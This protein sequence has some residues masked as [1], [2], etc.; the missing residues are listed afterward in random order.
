[1]SDVPAAETTWEALRRRLLVRY[2]EFVRRLARRLGSQEL[3]REIMHETYLRFE[4][5]GD[6]G[7]IH[8]PD[9]Y[10]YRT[11]INIAKNRA[12]AERRHL[13]ASEV[14]ELLD[15]ADE[16][17]DALRIAAS[18]S[19][20]ALVRTVLNRM[21]SR[22]REIFEASW[23]EEVPHAELAQRY[24]VHLRTIQREVEQATR[25]VR[26]CFQEKAELGRRRSLR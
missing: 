20:L 21:P 16:A 6:A 9:G 3:A 4:R 1:M 23:V 25:F 7:E 8:N 17:P 15:I 10:I 11:A 19:D 13:S 5:L 24:G 12:L 14:S 22:R 18:N 2:D 26:T